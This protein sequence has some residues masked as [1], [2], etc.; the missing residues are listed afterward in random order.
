MHV[1]SEQDKEEENGTPTI[2]AKD[3]KTKMITARATPSKGME[4]CAAE[5]AK[6]TVERLGR[7]KI[8]MGSDSEP[9]ISVRKEAAKSERERERC[10]D[11]VG[12]CAC[13]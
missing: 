2:V 3:N 5:S 9:A 11:S 13:R 4:S 10:G 6:N 8:I 7:D 1:H 12:R